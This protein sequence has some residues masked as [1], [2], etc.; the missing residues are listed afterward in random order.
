MFRDQ[1]ATKIANTP[2]KL[3]EKQPTEFSPLQEYER[4][5]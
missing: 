1:R 2:G 3:W 4:C 5:D